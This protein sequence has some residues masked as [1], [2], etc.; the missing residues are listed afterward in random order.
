MKQYV[1]IA[2]VYLLL[3]LHVYVS[4][5]YCVCMFMCLCR[6]VAVSVSSN[7][8]KMCCMSEEVQERHLS[9]AHSHYRHKNII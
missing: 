9:F 7:Q 5:C 2:S 8:I 3:Y 6:Y 1:I 4:V